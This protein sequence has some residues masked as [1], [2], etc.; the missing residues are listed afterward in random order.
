VLPDTGVWPAVP[1]DLRH[2]GKE[3]W[4]TVSAASL[5]WHNRDTELTGELSIVYRN[6]TSFRLVYQV[7]RNYGARRYLEDLKYQ[8]EIA[9]Q[10]GCVYYHYGDIRLSKKEKRAS[11]FLIRAVRKKSVG[12]GQ[13][14]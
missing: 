10:S 5:N 2:P 13:V 6:T 9:F 14:N 7:E 3:S 12:A 1:R 11:N 4:K 8:I